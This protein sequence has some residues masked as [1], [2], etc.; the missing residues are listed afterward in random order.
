M[1]QMGTG[2]CGEILRR[3]WFKC[4]ILRIS[5]YEDRTEEKIWTHLC[6]VENIQG[7]C[8]VGYVCLYVEWGIIWS[9]FT[10]VKIGVGVDN[11]LIYS[12]RQQTHVEIKCQLDAI[13]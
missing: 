6:V 13:N 3:V 12:R 7:I 5:G 8:S 1:W 4:S 10:V 9:Y 11:W 2:R